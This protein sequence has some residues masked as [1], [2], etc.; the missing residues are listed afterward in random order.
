VGFKPE[1]AA[2]LQHDPG[3]V[4]WLEIHAENYLLAGGPRL[5]LLRQMAERFPLS[6]HGVGLSIGGEQPLDRQHLARVA[7]LVKDIASASF[8]EHLA[9]STHDSS[10]FSDLLPLPYTNATLRRVCAHVEQVQE[11]LGRSLLLENPSSYLAFAESTWAEPAFLAEVARRTGCGL[12]LDVANVFISAKNLGGSAR[13]YLAAYALEK[14]GEI[15]LAGPTPDA[16]D[17]A[18]LIDSHARGVPEEVWELY[19]DVIARIGPCPSLIEWDNDVP[20]FDV[21]EAEAARAGVIMSR[22]VAA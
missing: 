15:H 10:Y 8:S 1:H 4:A 5:H 17:A 16:A 20:G 22:R 13:D 18:V 6:V 9:W 19:E 3:A 21:L 2:A 7:Q 11:A 14:V 12:L